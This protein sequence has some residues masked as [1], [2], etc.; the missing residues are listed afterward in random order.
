MVVEITCWMD[1]TAPIALPFSLPRP[2]ARRATGCRAQHAMV[3][4]RGASSPRVGRS[5]VLSGVTT[6]PLDL[7]IVGAGAAGTW[8]GDTVQRARPT[9]S[10]AIFER[11]DRVGGRL[12]SVHVDGVAHP[13]ELGGMRY[14]T[15]HRYVQA[16]VDE[17]EISTRP[18]DVRDRPERSYLRGRIGRGPD[19]PDA[20][21]GYH[22][23]PEE[24]GRS[25]AD[26]TAEV[27]GRVVPGFQALDDATWQRLRATATYRGRPLS[28][29]SMEDALSSVLS[30]EAHRFVTDAFGYDSGVRP[31]NVADAIPYFA[32]TGGP[33]GEARVPIAGMDCL[34]TALA[35]RFRDH[36]GV[37]HL[38]TE[39][40][41][42]AVDGES[43]V[44]ELGEGPIARASR[45]V[46]ALP[47]SGLTALAATS[48]IIDTAVH[49]SLYR[50]VE[51]IPATKLY[52][53]YDRPWWRDAPRPLQ[54]IRATT[55]RPSRKLWYLDDETD[56]PAALLAAYT[57]GRET[58]P[59]VALANGVS[60]GDPAPPPMLDAV[61]DDLA[62]LH[63]DVGAMPRPL[64]S[65]F[66]HWGADPVETG[67]HFWRAGHNSDAVIKGAEQPDP[68]VAIYLAGEGFSRAQAWVEGAFETAAAVAGRLLAG[69]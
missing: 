19:D 41:R 69:D 68:A 32:G 54:G 24:R 38:G 3:I 34:P 61:L 10:V 66:M 60:N 55:D 4:A 29:W 9:W 53:W 67:W 40:R 48:P 6:Q 28:N 11:L 44:L 22:L 33:T 26:L 37:L 7:A 20:G 52:V 64:G 21:A 49:R 58:A 59:M 35:G 25:A 39:V 2:G 5:R 51:Q 36:G 46:L 43:L 1:T 14:R 50:A 65:A 12:R 47:V 17:F 45:V 57:D 63:P 56:E 15:G 31:H 16:V 42:L 8:L 18:F 13:I 62:L 27:F 30:P 23:E